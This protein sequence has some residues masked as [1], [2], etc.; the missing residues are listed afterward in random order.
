MK[1][2]FFSLFFVILAT[3]GLYAQQISVVSPGGATSIYRTLQEAIEGAASG[4]TIYLPGGGFPI[5]ND[6]EITKKL[7]IIGIGHC[8]KNDNVDG[9]SIIT[10]KLSFK[11]GSSGSAV[12]GC[13]VTSDIDIYANVNDILIKY[14]NFYIAHVFDP[15]CLGTTVNQCYLRSGANFHGANGYFTHNISQ[16]IWNLDNGF[17]EYNI[18]TTSK[19]VF[20]SGN[21]N[22]CDNSSIIGNVLLAPDNYWQGGDCIVSGNMCTYNWVEIDPDLIKIDAD[23]SEVFENYNGGA[24]SPVSDF[25]FKGDYKQYESQ[26]GVYAGGVD[27]D[28]QLAPVPYIVAKHVDEQTDASGK[29]NVKIRVKAGQ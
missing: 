16:D 23:W 11:E 2:L 5:S 1:K 19:Y 26:V 24:I 7:T 27:F 12:I 10:G 6:L 18:F 20:G 9:T 14:C 15:S 22:R 13:Y 3:I 25:H 21:D 28:K 4:S 8:N 29:L 17:I